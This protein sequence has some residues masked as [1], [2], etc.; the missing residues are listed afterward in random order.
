MRR[1]LFILITIATILAAT[2]TAALARHHRHRSHHHG[3]RLEQLGG[4]E[5]QQT[6]VGSDQ[7]AG[8]VL[9][10]TGGVLTIRRTDGSMVSGNVNAETEF[11]CDAAEPTVMQTDDHGSSSGDNG[12]DN[13]DRGDNNGNQGD[14]NDQGE[15]QGEVEHACP[16][17]ALTPG[18]AVDEAELQVSSAGAIWRKVELITP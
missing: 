11:E 10:F 2:S 8:T 9:S 7:A 15:E 12:G 3:V 5:G 4:N 6:G 14:N 18:T 16:P 17:S 13:G 1:I